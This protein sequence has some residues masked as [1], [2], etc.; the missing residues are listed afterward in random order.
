M[1]GVRAGRRRASGAPVDEIP[2]DGVLQPQADAQQRVE[3]APPAAVPSEHGLV[4]IALEALPAETVQDAHGPAL[5][6]GEDP[7]GPF[8]ISCAFLSLTTRAS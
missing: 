6:A 7:V 3:R 2:A 8:G 1:D 5:Q 4:E